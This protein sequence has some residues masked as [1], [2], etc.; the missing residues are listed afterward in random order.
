MERVS[1][2]T[3]KG[4]TFRALAVFALVSFPFQVTPSSATQPAQDTVAIAALEVVHR[5]Q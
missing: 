3:R 2:G 1:G 5:A 4:L